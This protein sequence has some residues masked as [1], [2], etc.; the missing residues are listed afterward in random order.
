MSMTVK[1]E[2]LDRLVK[3]LSSPIVRRHMREAM[4]KA[5]TV[6]QHEAGLYPPPVPT[7]SRT[8]LLGRSWTTKV[9]ASSDNVIGEVFNNVEYAPFVQGQQQTWFHA[10]HGWQTLPQAYEKQSGEIKR[11]FQKGLQE[12]AD[13]IAS[14]GE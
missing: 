3:Q 11:L 12:A 6:M 5:V 7:Y 10:D 13:E 9:Q 8:L 4:S 1:I 2:G 14:G